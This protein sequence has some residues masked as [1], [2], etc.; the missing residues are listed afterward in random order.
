MYS[1]RALGH[2]RTTRLAYDLREKWVST[3]RCGRPITFFEVTY[4]RTNQ[5]ISFIVSS[6][7]YHFAGAVLCQRWPCR[8]SA[9]ACRRESGAWR[10]HRYCT[11]RTGGRRR[12][13]SYRAGRGSIGGRR[14]ETH[15]LFLR[16]PTAGSPSGGSAGLWSLFRLSVRTAQILLTLTPSL[17]GAVVR[18]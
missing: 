8:L 6:L 1:S 15:G 9:S 11:D 5:P 18:I 7:R 2:S 14:P 3:S 13:I 17:E 16:V 12:N 10:C 4:A